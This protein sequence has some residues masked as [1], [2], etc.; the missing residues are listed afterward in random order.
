[1]CIIFTF[2]WIGV[3][4]FFFFSNGPNSLLFSYKQCIIRNFV[5]F[6]KEMEKNKYIMW[7]RKEAINK[8][9]RLQIFPVKRTTM[10]N[11]TNLTLWSFHILLPLMHSTAMVFFT[12]SSQWNELT[13]IFFSINSIYNVKIKISTCIGICWCLEILKRN[14]SN[15]KIMQHTCMKCATKS[16][17]NSECF[18]FFFFFFFKPVHLDDVCIL[19]YISK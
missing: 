12:I 8:F 5:D 9:Q 3:F 13:G 15:K 19:A 11:E 17:Y 4:S 7:Y 16:L 10:V 14:Q 18:L 2:N 1:M 6:A